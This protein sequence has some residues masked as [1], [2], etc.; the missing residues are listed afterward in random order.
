MECEHDIF[1]KLL[2]QRIAS[3]ISLTSI[4]PNGKPNGYLNYEKL[5]D[6]STTIQNSPGTDLTA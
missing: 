6:C 3:E 2:Q 1:G 5:Y 4:L